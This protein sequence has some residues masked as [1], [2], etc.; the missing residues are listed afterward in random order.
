MPLLETRASSSASAY[1]LTSSS[2]WG[3]IGS[4]TFKYSGPAVTDVSQ[5]PNITTNLSSVSGV[6]Y[7]NYTIKANGSNKNITVPCRYDSTNG[8]V[9]Q[10][11][12]ST[13]GSAFAQTTS[14]SA[15]NALFSI[16]TDN[17]P[18]DH[19]QFCMI[20]NGKFIIN[21]DNVNS[22]NS[23]TAMPNGW[24]QVSGNTITYGRG[25]ALTTVLPDA[26]TT[27]VG[28][29]ATILAL[30]QTG[31]NV[32]IDYT[33]SRIRVDGLAWQAWDSNM[34]SY[35]GTNSLQS[36]A[37]NNGAMFLSDSVN[38][39]LLYR[40]NSSYA[41]RV[42]MNLSTGAILSTSLQPFSQGMKIQYTEE[43][44]FGDQLFAVDGGFTY[45][46]AT[47]WNM[48]T[49]PWTA[50]TSFATGTVNSYTVGSLTTQTGYDMFGSIDPIDG[51]VWLNDWGHDDAGWWNATA[52]SDRALTVVKTN[53]YQVPN[54]YVA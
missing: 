33:N 24:G 42:R 4:K 48:G 12:Y 18:D 34:N 16:G 22:W 5:I 38:G 1:G 27:E 53:M 30:T 13:Y 51:A 17:Q 32:Y 52:G 23:A 15:N 31:S 9:A 43:D 8:L 28:A 29:A 7:L 21:F 14:P 6:F 20:G 39:F 11:G 44:P 49:T 3:Q 45:V 36:Q 46:T 2:V 25:N 54:T 26:P 37:V 10:S 41:V 50:C 19:D 47:E 35:L 40:F